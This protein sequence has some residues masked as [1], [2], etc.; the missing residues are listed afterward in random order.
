M[1]PSVTEVTT[2]PHHDT[3]KKWRP[4]HFTNQN[5]PAFFQSPYKNT[6]Q[7]KKKK[8]KEATSVGGTTAI[9][10]TL[11]MQGLYLFYRTP[12]KVNIRMQTIPPFFFSTFLLLLLLIVISTFTSRLPCH[13]KSTHAY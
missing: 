3:T 10:R 4:I 12:V 2:E 9:A 11:M 7:K 5:I 8:A 13:G 1:V 6:I